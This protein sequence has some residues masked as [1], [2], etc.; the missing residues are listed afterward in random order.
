MAE[1]LETRPTADDRIRAALWFA[2]R[3]FGVFSVWSTTPQGECRCPPDSK[4]RPATGGPCSAPGKHPIPPTGFQA[5]TTDPDRIRSMLSAGSEPNW[6]LVAPDGVFVLDVDGDGVQELRNLIARLGP[7]PA[8][9]M[10]RTAHGAHVFLRWPADVPR[11]IGQLW[12]FVTRWGSGSGAG[13][14]IG[15]RSVHASGAIYEP[16]GKTFEIAE[17]PAFWAADAVQAKAPA[18][19]EAITVAAGG[20]QL[21]ERVPASASRYE[22]IRDYTAHLYNAAPGLELEDRFELVRSRLAP[23][24]ESPLTDAELRSRFDRTVSNIG[25]RL[26]P[27]R[28]P[29]IVVPRTEA[30]VAAGEIDG[31]D[32]LELILPPLV[33]I[34]P[35][36]VPEG[37]TVLAG[38][39]KLGKS[40]LVYQLAAEVALG[41]SLLEQDVDPGDVLYLA[42]EDGRRRGQT[43]LRNALGTRPMPRGRLTVRWS[44]ARLG[45]GLEDELVA[46]L[47]K[48]PSARL[49]AIDTLQKVRARADARRNAYEVDVEDLGRLQNLFRDRAVGLLIVHHTKKDHADDFL[50][51]V[52][53]TY[54]ITGSA[55]TT[56]VIKRTRNEALAKIL[57]TGRDVEEVEQAATFV[58]GLWTVAPDSLGEASFERVEIYRVIEAEG[59]IFPAAIAEL[60]GSSR[61]SVQNIVGRMVGQGS[62][63]RTMK[64]YIVS[65]IHVLEDEETPETPETHPATDTATERE[66]GETNVSGVSG[67]RARTHAG[68]DPRVPSVSGDTETPESGGTRAPAQIR[69]QARGDVSLTVVRDETPGPSVSTWCFYPADHPFRHRDVLTDSPWCEICSPREE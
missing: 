42:L 8:T 58:D 66:S 50:A 57:V 24:F 1:A 39:P 69:A 53:G 45:E 67:S 10:T 17:L 34:V 25:P 43:R 31:A 28:T 38:P 18:D 15:P 63:V 6:G 7:L 27:P 51:S 12:G 4:T 37:T 49:V 52:S 22:A 13:Y 14:V 68:G 20:Y 64:G 62:I 19:P 33:W 11:P 65:R 60:V 5:A 9:L 29:T 46:W 56:L 44:S 32:L 41:G 55:D 47:D 3:G 23:R 59:P 61:Q 2:E 21:P 26:G 30:E 36:F 48:H 35:R 16:I 54:G 40:S